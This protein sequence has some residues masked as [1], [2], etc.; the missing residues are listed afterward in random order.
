MVLYWDIFGLYY[1]YCGLTL[2]PCNGNTKLVTLLY[3]C[4]DDKSPSLWEGLK[5]GKSTGL[6]LDQIK[7]QHTN[8]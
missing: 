2:N 5:D 6:D 8:K 3:R 1:P 7:R 4:L